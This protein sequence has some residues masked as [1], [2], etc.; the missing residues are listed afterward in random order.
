MNNIEL[1][2]KEFQ[3]TKIEFGDEILKNMSTK[4][5]DG[6]IFPPYIPFV[7]QKYNDYKIL[8][9][10]TA[11]NIKYN[12]FRNL[13]VNNLDKLTKRLYYFDD[14][15]S[16]YP[17]NT[18]MS[19]QHI[20]INPYQTGVVAAL[21][22]VFIYSKFGKKIENLDEINNWIGISNYYKFSLNNRKTDINPE[23]KIHKFIKDKTQI[24][25]YW[26]VNDE[27]VKME[28]NTLTPNYILSFNGRKLN[29]LNTQMNG[30]VIRINDPSW[31]LQG[32][33]RYKPLKENG[34]WWKIAN[35]IKEKEIN[36]LINVYLEFIQGD[37]KGKKDSI[38]IYL[39]KYYSEWRIKNNAR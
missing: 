31:I 25:D 8:V 17:E 26:S 33:G 2:K 36:E 3:K 10:S 12:G 37:Y 14:F 7:G 22:G 29:Q 32:G 38:R 28:L 11:Q 23:T 18:K 4:T 15:K 21:L 20:A 9:Y 24:N 34:S 1:L 6:I 5:D 19:Y 35:R 16:K 13:Y 30:K 39:L 27:L